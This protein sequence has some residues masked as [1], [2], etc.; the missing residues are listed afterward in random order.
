MGTTSASTQE[1]LAKLSRICLSTAPI[2]PRTLLP[3][4]WSVDKEHQHHFC[5][6]MQIHGSHTR[7]MKQNLHFTR[8]K[9]IQ[10]HVKDW[11]A[12]TWGMIAPE[13][14]CTTLVLFTGWEAVVQEI[15]TLGTGIIGK[16]LEFCVIKEPPVMSCHL[17]FVRN[18]NLMIQ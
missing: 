5:V 16:N 8:S 7:F 3:K 12:S 14:G 10:M 2:L 18:I 4:V 13:L 9:L 17:E 1:S 6:R 15:E 11:E